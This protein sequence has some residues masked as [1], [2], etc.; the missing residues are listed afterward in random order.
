MIALPPSAATVTGTT[1]FSKDLW[2]NGPAALDAWLRDPPRAILAQTV[3]QSIPNDTANTPIA[4]DQVIYD[5]YNRRSADGTSWA[6]PAAGVYLVTALSNLAWT[7]A[8]NCYVG[9]RLSVLGGTSWAVIEQPASP[10]PVR[11]QFSLAALIPL[12]LGDGVQLRIYQNS[13][14]AQPTGFVTGGCRLTA[15]WIALSPPPP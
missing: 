8:D 4:F 2:D 7:G 11:F 14:T 5:N 12:A 15:R 9:N 3:A 10:G 1:V 6:A 13:G